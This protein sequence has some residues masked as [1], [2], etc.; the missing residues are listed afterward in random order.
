MLNNATQRL[1]RPYILAESNWNYIKDAD[2]ELAI[3]PWGATEALLP[4]DADVLIEN[5]ETGRTIARHNLK[6]IDTLFESTACLIGNKESIS[7][8]R[9]TE[10]IR[11]LTE[12]LKAGVERN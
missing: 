5:T 8:T 7:D 9:K 2:F 3:L 6:I 1:M 10:R 11:S 12:I 4:E